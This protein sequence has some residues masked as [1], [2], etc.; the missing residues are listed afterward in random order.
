MV[1]I[2]VNY[3]MNIDFYLRIIFKSLMNF[4]YYKH[5]IIFIIIN[6]NL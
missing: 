3:L 1:F 4:I 5:S 2:Y 6:I